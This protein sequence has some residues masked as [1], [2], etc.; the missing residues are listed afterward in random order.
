MRVNIKRAFGKLDS[1]LLKL[2]IVGAFSLNC[3]SVFAGPLDQ[4]AEPVSNPVNFEDPRIVSN[5]KPIFAYHKIDDKFV[6]GGGD[7]RIYA[8]QARFALSDDLAIIATKDGIVDL[9]PNSVLDDESGLANVAGGVKYSFYK[10]SAQSSIATAGL[11]YEAPLGAERVLQGQGK[12]ILNPFVS[13]ATVL[14]CE[15]QPLNLVGSTGLRIPFSTD[16]SMFYDASLHADTRFDW[17]SPLVEVNLFHVLDA[18]TRLPVVDEG[19]DFFNLGSS[20]SN[21]E[22]MVT[23]A[24]GFRADLMKDL[25]WGTA[26]EFPLAKGPGTRITE[27]RLTTD[28]TYKF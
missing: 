1:R 26:Y 23:A 16:D 4:I 3:S 18:G 12:G 27:W 10:D 2:A 6:T 9:N 14:G 15:E 20:K 28:L 11:R 7:V 21:G 5:L 19:Q 8:L 17:F 24:A 22:T 25:S 13:A